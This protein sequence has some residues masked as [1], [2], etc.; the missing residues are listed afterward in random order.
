M[1]LIMI[2]TNS[3]DMIKEQLKNLKTN[4]RFKEGDCNS[5]T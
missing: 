4:H 5:Y 2:I 3:F 1:Y